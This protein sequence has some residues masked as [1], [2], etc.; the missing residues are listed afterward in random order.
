MITPLV[1]SGN[2]LQAPRRSPEAR[3][4]GLA[5]TL[6]LLE[7]ALDTETSGSARDVARKLEAELVAVD[8]ALRCHV[9][10]A[11]GPDGLFTEIDQV[12]PT[13]LRRVEKLRDDHCRLMVQS[14]GLRNMVRAH[15]VSGSEIRTLT[16]E[17]LSAIRQHQ[18]EEMDAVYDSIN[19][20]IGAG[21]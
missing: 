12:R 7:H 1:K 4:D 15:A 9:A 13:M 5:T 11:E 17:L 3:D 19:L 6:K 14:A 10:A 2:G 18:N 8:D 16:N 20:D 21:D